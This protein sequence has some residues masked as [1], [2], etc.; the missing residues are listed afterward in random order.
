METSKIDAHIWYRLPGG[1]DH[2]YLTG[3][4]HELTGPLDEQASGFLIAPFD[5]SGRTPLFLKP[6]D[7]PSKDPIRLWRLP[8]HPASEDRLHFE[9]LVTQAKHAVKD[10]LFRKLVV[11]RRKTEPFLNDPMQLFQTLK[12]VYPNAFVYL[13]TSPQTGTWMGAS[14]EP[15]LKQK[16]GI[17]ETVALAGTRSVDDHIPFGEKE[18]EEQAWVSRYIEQILKE[19][20]IEFLVNGP[21]VF[22]TGNLKHL[23]TTFHFRT[24]TS[25]KTLAQTLHPTPAVAGWP[26]KEAIDWLRAKEGIDR[27]WY[28]GYL[29]PVS[30]GD[31]QLYVNLRCL[32]CHANS[33]A[34][35]A[36]AG[37]TAD[38][39]PEL[40]WEETQNKMQTLQK[41][42]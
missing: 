23:K 33:S 11:A 15:L 4:M 16:E 6:S 17:F 14:P 26:M 22:N 35:Y 34:L 13:L 40:E 42:F 1:S 2:I 28:A 31:I 18:I 39:V 5:A 21:E 27:S 36:G 19:A 25:W 32:Q 10:G 8:H 41:L 3:S 30:N 9:Q 7:I 38:S 20:Q 24:D 29:G 12:T 37:I